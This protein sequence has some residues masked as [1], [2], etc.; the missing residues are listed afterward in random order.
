[1]Q[2]A[3]PQTVVIELGGHD[4]LKGSSRAATA[5]NL[6]KLIEAS[7]A[8]GADVVMMEIPRGVC[9]DW[10][11]GLERSLARQYDLELISDTPIRKL[12]MWSPYAPPGMWFDATT[13]LGDDGLHPNERG[14]VFLADRVT[15]S[16]IRMY[17]TKI[18]K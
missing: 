12:I 13:H 6:R 5:E 2:A 3:K 1:M 17:G 18:G 16:L 9:I 4:F 11:G 15:E 8:V 7:Q 14:N 10:F